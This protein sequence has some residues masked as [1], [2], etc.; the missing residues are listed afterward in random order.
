MGTIHSVEY[1][2]PIRS[3]MAAKLT[4]YTVV[5]DSKKQAHNL[6]VPVLGV[7]RVINLLQ[8]IVL[9]KRDWNV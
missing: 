1:K 2:H 6:D 4:H 7:Y 5:M 9:V 3:D 8:Q